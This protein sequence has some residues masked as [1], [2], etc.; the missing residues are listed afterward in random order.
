MNFILKAYIFPFLSICEYLTLGRQIDYKASRIRIR[1]FMKYFGLAPNIKNGL[2]VVVI[3]FVYKR[4][5]ST[6][7]INYK[8]F[9]NEFVH[10]SS[11]K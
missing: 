7:Y 4:I 10:T 6:F 8:I 11:L 3:S 1:N 9:D 5:D 2:I